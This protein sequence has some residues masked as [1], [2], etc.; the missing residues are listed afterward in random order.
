VRLAILDE[1]HALGTKVLFAMIR[2][3]SRQPTPEALKLVAYRPGFYGNWMKKVAHEAMRGPSPWSVA[4]RE[5]MAATVSKAN[6]CEYCVKAHTAVSTAAYGDAAKVAKALTDL[7]DAPIGEPLR[8]TLS[9]LRKLA[10]ERTIGVEDVRIAMAA[11]V[12]KDQLVDA[13]AVAFSFNVMNR[14]ADAFGFAVAGPEAFE[15]GAKYLLARG[16]K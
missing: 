12:S 5:L 14:L 2:T 11:G 10:V 1:G 15:A 9:L 3:F 4:D 8:A 7:H 6:E 16:Y 13:L